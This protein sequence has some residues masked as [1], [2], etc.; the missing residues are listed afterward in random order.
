MF[1][2]MIYFMTSN[3]TRGVGGSTTVS[4]LGGFGYKS[5]PRN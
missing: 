4:Y 5:L 1:M 3:G 2:S